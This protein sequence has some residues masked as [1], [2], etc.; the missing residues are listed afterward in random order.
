MG[1]FGDNGRALTQDERSAISA[2]ERLAKRWPDSLTL[3]SW[4]GSLHVFDSETWRDH[5]RERSGISA[6]DV[7]ICTIEGIPNDGG[8]P[9]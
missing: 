7:T 9:D 8:D 4:S 3:F 2:L 5:D 6:N 1:P